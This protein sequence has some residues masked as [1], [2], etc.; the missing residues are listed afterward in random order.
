MKWLNLRQT[1]EQAKDKLDE[2][3]MYRQI[4]KKLQD[5]KRYVLL[6]HFE[7]KIAGH[8]WEYWAFI[9]RR[10]KAVFVYFYQKR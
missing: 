2:A 7:Q 6:N 1:L 5:T 8:S 3:A 9:C 4:R 10:R